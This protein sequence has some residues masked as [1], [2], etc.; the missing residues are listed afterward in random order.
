MCDKYRGG[1]AGHVGVGLSGVPGHAVVPGM[2]HGHNSNDKGE[3]TGVVSSISSFLV[4]QQLVLLR[5]Y[6]ARIL[7]YIC[8]TIY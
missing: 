2:M 3:E 5:C 4:E 7:F 8:K 6:T 1:G